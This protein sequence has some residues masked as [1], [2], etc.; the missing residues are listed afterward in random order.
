VTG[1]RV[2][3]VRVTPWCRWTGNYSYVTIQLSKQPGSLD[4]SQERRNEGST[5]RHQ[6]QVASS[7][8]LPGRVSFDTRLRSISELQQGPVPAYT[9]A[10]ARVAWQMNTQL[11]LAFV[12]QDVFVRTTWSGR[13]E[14]ARTS[15]SGAPRMSV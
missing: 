8:D 15:K 11:E 9:S 2:A 14:P 7:L 12:A 6:L 4:G 1:E 5:P 3:D 10:D 13:V